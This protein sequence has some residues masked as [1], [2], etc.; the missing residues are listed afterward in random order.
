MNN[1]SMLKKNYGLECNKGTNVF[2][3][4]KKRWPDRISYGLLKHLA[5]ELVNLDMEKSKDVCTSD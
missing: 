5:K 4:T 3:L 2:I 1:L